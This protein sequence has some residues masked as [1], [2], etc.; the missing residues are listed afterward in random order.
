M[1]Q[2][3]AVSTPVTPPRRRVAPIIV[4]A[5]AACVTILVAVVAYLLYA[6]RPV[7]AT[8]TVTITENVLGSRACMGTND[9]EDLREGAAVVVRALSNEI[10]ASGQ[11]DEGVGGN[12]IGG[13]AQ[14][15]RFAFSVPGVPR[16]KF[17][18]IAVGRRSPV[19]VTY[20]QL[21]DRRITLPEN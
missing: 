6:D 4:T 1:S 10:I 19:V 3:D 11:L 12:P 8:G 7:T 5:V 16:E 21:V 15:C 18:R 9:D 20:K 17:Y 14:T 13:N 2:L